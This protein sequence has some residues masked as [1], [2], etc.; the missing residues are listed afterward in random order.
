MKNSIEETLINLG[1]C[2]RETIRDYFPKVRDRDDI[3]VKKCE[4]S[5][6]IFLSRTDHMSIEHY[7]EKNSF[8]DC[9]GLT[10]KQALARSSND[11]KRRAAQIKEI[12]TG[13]DWLDIGSS[14][15]GLLELLEPFAGSISTVEPQEIARKELY[16]IGYDTYCSLDELG[17]VKFDVI[18]LFHVFEHITNPIETLAKIKSHLRPGGKLVI[19]VPHAN[20]FLINLLDLDEFK[21]FT[22]WSE[23]LILHT[24]NSLSTMLRYAGYEN[25]VTKGIQRYPLANHLYW[26][27]NKKPAGHIMWKFLTDPELDSSY[28]KMLQSIDM[29]DTIISFSEL[30]S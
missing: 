23:H 2:D 22:F 29:N 5:G 9:D 20:D 25:V 8:Q 21:Y 28:E 7:I 10:R 30:S 3:A 14:V 18:T 12:V 6:V 16:D 4:K 13:R 11:D 26:L 19:E 1:I 17:D 15:G 24:R 27:K